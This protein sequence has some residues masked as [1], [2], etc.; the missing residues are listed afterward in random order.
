YVYLGQGIPVLKPGGTV[1][2]LSRESRIVRSLVPDSE[3]RLFLPR[4]M[5][6]GPGAVCDRVRSILFG[7]SRR[8]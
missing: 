8:G 2:E 6:E 3:Y 1:T 5:V 4:E 7:D